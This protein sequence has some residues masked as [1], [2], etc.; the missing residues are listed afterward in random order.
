MKN[1]R[2]EFEVYTFRRKEEQSTGKRVVALEG[3]VCAGKTTVIEKLR[4]PSAAVVGEYSE[5]VVSA[6]RD[7]PKFPPADEKA[8]KD[9]FRFFFELEVKR[10]QNMDASG[11]NIVLLDR[12]IYTLLAFEVGASRLT[13]INIL[14][15][16]VEYLEKNRDEIIIPEQ[17]IYMDVPAE[18]SRRRAEE[19]GILIAE[20]LLT[21]EFNEGFKDFFMELKEKE[22]EMVV[23]VRATKDRQSIGKEVSDLVGAQDSI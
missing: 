21:N 18:V 8:A 2:Q 11:G 19:G 22:P 6:T 1:E 5:Y 15:W 23:V 13:G 3:P 20:F 17:V 12:S 9:S 14:P 16:A 7:F 10:K 4:N